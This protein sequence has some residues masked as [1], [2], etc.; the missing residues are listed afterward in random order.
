VEQTK[1]LID[2]ASKFYLDANTAVTATARNG[3]PTS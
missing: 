3:G 2:A 1:Q